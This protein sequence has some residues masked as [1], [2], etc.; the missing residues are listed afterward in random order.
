MKTDSVQTTIEVMKTALEPWY[1][2]LTNPSKAQEIVLE[3]LLTGYNQTEYGR[4]YKS[5]NVGSYA[6]FRKAFPVQTYHDFKPYIDRVLAGD[7]F[8]LLNE[9]PVCIGQTKGTTGEAKLF[10]FTP[11]QN[12]YTLQMATRANIAYSFSKHNFEFMSG[13]RLNLM[14]SAKVGTIKVGGRELMYGH[15]SA[16][17]SKLGEEDHTRI[18]KVTPTQNEMDTLPAEP[19]KENWERRYEFAYLK[20]RELN[21]TYTGMTPNVLVGFG[22]YLLREHHIS[23]KDIWKMQYI[24]VGGFAAI[25]TH[26]VPL[27]HALYGKSVDIWETYGANEASIGTQIDDKKAWVPFYDINLLEVQTINGIKPMHEM[28][29]GE[30]GALIIST[31][32]L[33]RYRIG[34]LILAFESPYF[35]CIG[36]EN[37]KLHPYHFGKL[38][39]KSDFNFSKPQDLVSWR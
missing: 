12:K 21:V 13:Y 34:D 2:S 15:I 32:V 39:G 38:T 35:Q 1:Q 17:T 33:P 22:R 14:G 5:E 6:D 4:K 11:I 24:G 18:Q 25:Q 7:T 19:S 10:P 9:E 30:I 36:R 29:P 3:R 26:F 16:I 23:P 28:I 37:T 27:I 8:A 31:P 20:A